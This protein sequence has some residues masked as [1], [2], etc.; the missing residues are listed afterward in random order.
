[1]S[2][3]THGVTVIGVGSLRFKGDNHLE[4]AGSITGIL[5]AANVDSIKDVKVPEF[6]KHLKRAGGH[7]DRNVV[8]ITIKMKT[9][10]DICI[11]IYI[12]IYIYII[13][14]FTSKSNPMLYYDRDT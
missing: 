8:G 13:S 2:S 5:N 11:Y 7:T 1:M 10:N 14:D 4:V 12:Y 9:L 6:D 3:R